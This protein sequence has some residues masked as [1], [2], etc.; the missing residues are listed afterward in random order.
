MVASGLF[1]VLYVCIYGHKV[2]QGYVDV[3]EG[4]AICGDYIQLVILLFRLR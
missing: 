2:G 3:T 4:T 1:Y